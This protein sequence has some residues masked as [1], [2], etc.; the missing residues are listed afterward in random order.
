MQQKKIKWNKIEKF[1]SNKWKID[2]EELWCSFPFWKSSKIQYLMECTWK[3]IRRNKWYII[4]S[5]LPG[6]L[7]KILRN[8][9]CQN[10]RDLKIIKKSI[11]D[12][13]LWWINTGWQS[14]KK[15]LM[16]NNS[17]HNETSTI[18]R[19]CFLIKVNLQ[20]ITE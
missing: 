17:K 5:N 1:Y 13:F 3:E 19:N 8:L 15:I 11:Q 2:E 4:Y 18:I 12:I 20:G 14:I 10:D 7:I 9:R 6:V 16:R